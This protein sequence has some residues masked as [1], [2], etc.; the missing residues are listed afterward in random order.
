MSLTGGF[1]CAMGKLRSISNRWWQ[2]SVGVKYLEKSTVKMLSKREP[3]MKISCS[4]NLVTM[5]S[6]NSLWTKLQRKWNIKIRAR[7][8][9]RRAVNSDTE[10]SGLSVFIFKRGHGIRYHGLPEGEDAS[11]FLC[12]ELVPGYLNGITGEYA[13]PE[14]YFVDEQEAEAFDKQFP[15]K[16]KKKLPGQLF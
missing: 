4:I 2:D 15:Y 9:R 7:R 12:K 1:F 3:E 6:L 11:F 5:D 14:G 10:K 16:E 8:L 13:T